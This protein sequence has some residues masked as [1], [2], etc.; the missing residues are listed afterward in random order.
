M[1]GVLHD[2]RVLDFTRV[3]AGPYAT[4]ILADFGAEVIRVE[5]VSSPEEDTFSRGYY[6]TWN[7]NKLAISLNLDT[8]E[9]VGLAL[10]L[11]RISDVVAEN[12]APRVMANW[13]LDYDSLKT[14]RSDIIMLSMSVMGQTGP[15]RDYAGFGPTVHALSGMT[16]LTT[17]PGQPPTGPGFAYADHV[18]G[19]YG[20]LA[21]LAALEERARTGRGQHIDLAETE[22][23]ASLLGEALLEYQSGRGGG[24]AGNSSPAA[25][26]HNVYPCRGNDRWCA[27]AVYGEAEWRALKAALGHP[28]WA[29]EAQFASL[30]SRLENQPELDRLI[31][32]WTCQHS[33]EEVMARLQAEGVRSGVVHDAADL[34]RDPHLLARGFFVEIEHPD[35]GKT[36]SDAQPIRLPDTPA[37]YGRAAPLHSQDNG[38]V[39]GKLLGLSPQEIDRLCQQGVI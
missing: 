25:A 21:V 1:T 37:E 29:N 32:E 22:A 12:F 6:A 11:A 15:L 17:F 24:P 26:P 31:G 28:A 4:R 8:P 2:I 20:A 33:P 16:H 34:A 10:R 23:M 7:R 30:A 27:I 9:G 5:P 36:V 39:Y 14:L 35:L 38:Y 13:G 18:A 19:L 3:L